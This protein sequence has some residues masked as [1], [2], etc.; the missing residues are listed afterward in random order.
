MKN[1]AV[2]LIDG[3]PIV[4]VIHSEDDAYV[5][6]RERVL[7]VDSANGNTVAFPLE[8]ILHWIVAEPGEPVT[9]E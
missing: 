7:Y 9:G 8:N 1:V 5:D 3:P 2:I 4:G 6:S